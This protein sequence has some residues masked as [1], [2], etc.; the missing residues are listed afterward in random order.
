MGIKYKI[1]RDFFKAWTPEMAYVLGF[2]AAD[3]SLEDASY[4]RGKYLRICSSDINILEKI[5][6]VM[7]SEHKIITIKPKE[8]LSRSK[9]C[10]SKRKIYAEN[11]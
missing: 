2:I 9:K 6:A 3:G 7:N 8:F 1:N 5:K 10:I 4:L 11:R